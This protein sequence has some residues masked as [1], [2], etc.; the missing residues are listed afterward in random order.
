MYSIDTSA[1]I[2]AWSRDYRP[3][4]FPS[5]WERMARLIEEH[6]LVASMSVRD[7]IEKGDDTL[8]DWA[9]RDFSVRPDGAHRQWRKVPPR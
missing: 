6:R 8:A 1:L 3:N 4:V 7:E 5:L 9:S 2:D